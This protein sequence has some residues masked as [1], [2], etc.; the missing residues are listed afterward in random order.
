MAKLR[1]ITAEPRIAPWLGPQRIEPDQIVTVPDAHYDAYACQPR[2]WEV[3]EE[4]AKKPS[5][6]KSSGARGG[7]RKDGE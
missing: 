7:A 1:L 3:V 6:G 2:V 4:P 5:S